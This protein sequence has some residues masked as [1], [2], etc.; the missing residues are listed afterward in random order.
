MIIINGVRRKHVPD[1]LKRR[2]L[3]RFLDCIAAQMT[4][5]LQDIVIENLSKFTDF[6]C[7]VKKLR[8]FSILNK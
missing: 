6:I 3:K 2:S 4:Q 7:G 1:V 8:F 5:N